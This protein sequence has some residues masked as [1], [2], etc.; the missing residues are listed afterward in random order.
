M[1][2]GQTLADITTRALCG[3]EEVI[4][5]VEPDMSSYMAILL[6]LLQGA[7]GIL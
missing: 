3:L 2:Q 7:G 5:E 1:K 4:Q 6:Q